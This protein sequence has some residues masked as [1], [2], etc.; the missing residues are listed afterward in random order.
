MTGANT[1]NWG[2]GVELPLAEKVQLTAETY[3]SSGNKPGQQLGVRWEVQQ[4][5]KVSAALGR[6]AAQNTI[7]TGFSWEF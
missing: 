7:F 2:L 1:S 3:G 4:G 6:N 5:L